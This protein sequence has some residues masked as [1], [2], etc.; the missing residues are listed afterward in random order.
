MTSVDRWQLPDGIEEVLPAQAATAERLRRRLLDLYR[1]WGYQ[2]VIPPLM[3]F[4]ESLLIGLGQDLDLLTFKL[5]DQV[6]GRMMGI[7]ADTTPQVARIDAH[8]LKRETPTRLCYMGTV[9]RTRADSL[10]G[11]RNPFQV[12]AELF[13]V[14]Q[15]AEDA[16]RQIAGYSHGMRKKT[17]LAAALVHRP[18]LLMLDEPFEGVDPVSTRAMRSML[19]SR[20]KN[21]ANTAGLGTDPCSGPDVISSSFS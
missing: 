20:W 13:G 18:R 5:T 6:S 8:K 10:D 9:L 4:T 17:A 15:I 1:S 19:G 11:S 14:L 16:H 3:E 7:R 12:G 2:L 21:D